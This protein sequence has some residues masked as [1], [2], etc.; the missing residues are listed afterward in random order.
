MAN[1]NLPTLTSNYV[2]FVDEVKNRDVDSMTLMANMPSSPPYQGIRLLRS[3]AKFQEWNGGA[4]G[5]IVLSPAGGGTGVTSISALIPQLGLGSMA[6]Q[7]SNNISVTGGIVQANVIRNCSYDG[8]AYYA[9]S[10]FTFQSVS[11]SIPVTINGGAGQWT[12][13]I[14]GP[15]HGLMI[16]ACSGLTSENALYVRNAAGSK[17]GLIVRGDMGVFVYTGLV[18]PVGAGAFVPA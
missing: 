8:S 4:F 11:S 15:N 16:S 10:G 13:L 18:I 2:N 5:D 1:W 3:P 9:G 7:N 12:T 17:L 14:N 6:Y